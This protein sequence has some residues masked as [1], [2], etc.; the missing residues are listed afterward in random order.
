M[1]ITHT[2]CK[3]STPNT[4]A[5]IMD[6]NGRIAF[7]RYKNNIPRLINVRTS[8]KTPTAA[9]FIQNVYG[10]KVEA[11]P[12]E[13]AHQLSSSV[14]LEFYSLKLEPKPKSSLNEDN[15]NAASVQ[16]ELW[17]MTLKE[18]KD[19][20]EFADW[21][22]PMKMKGIQGKIYKFETYLTSN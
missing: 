4:V 3:M 1:S 20:V 7:D 15:D 18:L 14:H 10:L 2:P 6:N 11:H 16:E 22:F 17:W 19:Q 5:L 8:A 13:H 21:G 9:A 12:T